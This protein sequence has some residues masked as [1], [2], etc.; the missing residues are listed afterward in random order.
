M[1]NVK[2]FID[3][4]HG[5]TNVGAVANGLRESDINLAVSIKLGDILRINGYAIKYSRTSDIN[6]T[7]SERAQMANNWNANYFVS[8]HCNSA[9]SRQ[10]NGTETFVYKLGTPTAV[11]GQSIQTQLVLQNGLR[12]RGLKAAD[13]TVLTA[14]K[15]PAA[16]VELA[17]I[18]N[19]QEA[20]LLS[21]PEFQMRCARG[22]ANGIIDYV[23]SK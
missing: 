14:T 21:T 4:G 1:I 20:K 16:L 6:L 19:P 22:I 11:Y 3:P 5:G 7:L 9:A 2:I 15:M 8:I 10:A 13:F 18:S 12:N 23:S 17:F